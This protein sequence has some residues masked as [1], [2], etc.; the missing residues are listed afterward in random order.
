MGKRILKK[1]KHYFEALLDIIFPIP[2][3][4][5]GCGRELKEYNNFKL[6]PVCIGKVCYYDENDNNHKEHSEV[7]YDRCIVACT[8][9]GI[10]REMVHKIKYKDKREIAITIAAIMADR[11]IDNIGEFDYLVPVPIS[12]RKLKKRGYNHT[13]LIA[14]ELKSYLNIPVLDC[15][16]RIRD[17]QPQ[18][19]F[20]TSDRWYNVKDCFKCNQAMQG[21]KII[22]I[23]DIVTTG[24]TANYCALELKKSGAES[25]I[26]FSFAKSIQQ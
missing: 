18:V 17:T 20:N 3:V 24:A 26:M 2:Q 7:A 16:I 15:L 12:N 8:Y 6:C 19:L 22:L 10:V 1:I 11:N 14:L 4:C 9:E 5:N 13:K 25:V 21:K 23:D